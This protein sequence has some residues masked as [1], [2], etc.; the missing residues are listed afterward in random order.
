MNIIRVEGIE[1]YAHH[2]CLEEE[3]LIGSHYRVDVEIKTDFTEAAK[4]DDLSKTV[5]YVAVYQIVR[6]EMKVRAKLI[7]HVGQR[8]VDAIKTELDAIE[9]V[10]VKVSKLSPPINGNAYSVSIEIEN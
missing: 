6:R 4:Q 1:L 8:I 2:G 3:A 7:E 9:R 10:K 5:D